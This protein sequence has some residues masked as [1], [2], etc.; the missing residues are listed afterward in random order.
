MTKLTPVAVSSTPKTVTVVIGS[1]N[2]THAIIAVVGGTRYIRLATEAAAPRWMSRNKKELPP[3]V[4]PRTDQAM[5]PTNSVF[6]FIESVSIMASGKDATNAA[7]SCTVLA[8]RTS[9][10]RT[11]RFW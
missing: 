1:P 8:V 6:Q 4:K 10:G 2:K 11:N 9:H 3:I 7:P 5:A